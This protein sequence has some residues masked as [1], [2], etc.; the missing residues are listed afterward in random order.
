MA[1]FT[2]Y[3]QLLLELMNRARLDPLG[4]AARLG[5]DLNAGL[6]PGTITSATKQ[7]LAPNNSLVTASRAHSQHMINTDKFNHDGIGDGTPTSRMTAAGYTL[8]GTWMTGENIAWTGTTGTADMLSFTTQI[9]DNLFRSAGHRENTL[10]GGFREA[11]TGVVSGT[12]TTTRD[13]NAVMATENFGLSGSK[14]FVSGVAIN[15]TNGND[16][17]DV[18]EA[19]ANVKVA[20][21]TGGI[22][23]G[24]DISEAAGGYSVATDTGTHVITF[25]GG[26]LAAPVTATLYGEGSNVK[27]DLSGSNEILSSVTTVLGAGA[28]DLRLLGA[29]VANGFGNALDNALVGSKAANVLSGAAGND[30]I[31]GGAGN[32]VIAGGAGRDIMIGSLGADRFDF[33]A[34]SETSIIASARDVITDFTH[35]N[36]LALSDR[37]DLQTIDANGALATSAAFFWLG[38]AAFNGAPGRLRYYQEDPAATVSDKTIVEGDINGDKAADFRIEL[39]GLKALVAADFVL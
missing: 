33:N 3:E 5:I 10:N 25:S 16:F 31:Y 9:A 12:F 29:V 22:A 8:T 23:D 32:D 19:R 30:T 20:V 28:K 7:A 34:I 39:R 26:G 4:E 1:T 37:I 17:Y 35:N 15:D 36:T 38:T 24:T 21:S 13:W 11:G 2:A 18:G 27:A 6:A 14:V